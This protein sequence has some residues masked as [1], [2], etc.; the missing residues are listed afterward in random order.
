MASDVDSLDVT[1][2]AWMF[3]GISCDRIE[4]L[5]CKFVDASLTFTKVAQ[6]DSRVLMSI[7]IHRNSHFRSDGDSSVFES[8]WSH[9]DVST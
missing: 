6:E 7:A 4:L 2:R 9:G 3:G 1:D 8:Q 5:P